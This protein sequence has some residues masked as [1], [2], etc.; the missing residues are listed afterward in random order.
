MISCA[1][2]YRLTDYPHAFLGTGNILEESAQAE[3]EEE[4]RRVALGM[5]TSISISWG[6][7]PAQKMTIIR[8]DR[9]RGVGMF[10]ELPADET[11]DES[12]D[13]EIRGAVSL[14]V[15]KSVIGYH[16]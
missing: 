2:N 3:E 1:T 16:Q 7:K 8:T 12:I 14:D 9:R 5:P 11:A 10:K 6:S 13:I 4:I 15:L